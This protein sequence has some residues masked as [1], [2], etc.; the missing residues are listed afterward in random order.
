MEM[1][2]GIWFD[3]TLED[4]RPFV[5]GCKDREVTDDERWV[6]VSLSIEEVKEV[7][8]YL[9]KHLHKREP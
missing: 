9:S 5:V 4:G 8:E 1:N 3:D 6:L 7:Y 2:F